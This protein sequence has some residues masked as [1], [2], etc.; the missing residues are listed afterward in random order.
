LA[1]LA[2]YYQELWIAS[3]SKLVHFNETKR[4]QINLLNEASGYIL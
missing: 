3:E 1:D 4:K 2:D